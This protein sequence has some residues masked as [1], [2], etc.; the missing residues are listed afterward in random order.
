[1]LVV[2]HPHSN[3]NPSGDY[4]VVDYAAWTES[5][6]SPIPKVCEFES[7]ASYAEAKAACDAGNALLVTAE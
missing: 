6:S 1:M 2:L 3:T 5:V 7:F 4:R